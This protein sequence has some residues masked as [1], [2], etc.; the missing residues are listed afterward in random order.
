MDSLSIGH[1][2]QHRMLGHLDMP[3]TDILDHNQ[4]KEVAIKL[5][6]DNHINAHWSPKSTD[7]V[8]SRRYLVE[9]LFNAN[10]IATI[11]RNNLTIIQHH[12]PKTPIIVG[13]CN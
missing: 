10:N 12:S 13:L 6:I 7:Y 9:D 4:A 3:R 5:K 11:K 2:F 1:S 8:L